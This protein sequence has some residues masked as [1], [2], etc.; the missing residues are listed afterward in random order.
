MR[1][2]TNPIQSLDYYVEPM[3]HN[4]GDKFYAWLD[5]DTEKECNAIT[6][7]LGCPLGRGM[8]PE[9]AASDL[10][11]RTSWCMEAAGYAVTKGVNTKPE[12]IETDGAIS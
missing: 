3:P 11:R 2:S 12:L 5:R 10:V 7:N 9:S 6:A 1:T 4:S 8:S